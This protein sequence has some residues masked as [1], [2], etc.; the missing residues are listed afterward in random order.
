[1]KL[2]EEDLRSFIHERPEPNSKPPSRRKGCQYADVCD[3]YGHMAE[4]DGK[5]V[6]H[7]DICGGKPFGRKV[8]TDDAQN[9][10]KACNGRDSSM[11]RAVD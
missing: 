3:G 11:G 1:M 2:R 4:V 7:C 9:E 10:K 8:C 6:P 5:I